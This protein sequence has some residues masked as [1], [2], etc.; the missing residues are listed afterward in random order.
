MNLLK[1]KHFPL[2]EILFVDIEAL[3]IAQL[4]RFVTGLFVVRDISI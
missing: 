4:S 3:H 1:V 2:R